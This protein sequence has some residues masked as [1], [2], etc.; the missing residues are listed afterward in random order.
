MPV[1]EF[2][3]NVSSASSSSPRVPQVNTRMDNSTVHAE[4]PVS[5]TNMDPTLES[6]VANQTQSPLSQLPFL[7]ESLRPITLKVHHIIMNYY[8]KSSRLLSLT[9][10]HL[11]C[12]FL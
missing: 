6:G 5:T 8:F 11:F 4:P 7:R 1:L 3:T 10:K 9:I 2:E 12:K